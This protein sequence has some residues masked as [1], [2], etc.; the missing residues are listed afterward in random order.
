MKGHSAAPRKETELSVWQPLLAMLSHITTGTPCL[1]DKSCKLYSGTKQLCGRMKSHV[2]R[3]L[4][5]T[6]LVLLTWQLSQ[7]PAQEVF[8]GGGNADEHPP[9]Q[10]PKPRTG[11]THLLSSDTTWACEGYAEHIK[12][13]PSVLRS[14]PLSLTATP[15]QL[16]SAFLPQAWYATEKVDCPKSEAKKKTETDIPNTICQGHLWLLLNQPYQDSG[17]Q[18][19]PAYREV[20]L[21]FMVCPKNICREPGGASIIAFNTP[22]IW[23]MPL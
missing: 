3:L 19:K 13:S 20:R 23:C 5:D 17:C 9:V 4:V 11:C 14:F 2:K 21:H 1:M 15:I 12:L 8:K 22:H 10:Q 18:D 7:H 16:L 6:L